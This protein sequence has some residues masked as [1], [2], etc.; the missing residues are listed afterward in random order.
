M[1]ECEYETQ[2]YVVKVVRIHDGEVKLLY[3]ADDSTEE[4]KESDF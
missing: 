1:L 3:T 4:L 2:W